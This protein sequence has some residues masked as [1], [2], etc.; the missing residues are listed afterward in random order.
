MSIRDAASSTDATA[1]S[2]PS[3]LNGPDEGDSVIERPL[4]PVSEKTLARA[5][6]FAE[7]LFSTEAGPPDRA[8]IDWLIED[9]R[10]FLGRAGGNARLVLWACL[11]ACHWLAPLFIR[12]LPTLADLSIE[13]RAVAL[14][15]VERSSFGPIV[16]GPK[17]ILCLLWFEHPDTQRE[18]RTEP[19]CLLPVIHE[20]GHS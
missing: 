20:G 18:T 7:A 10:D 19:S 13:E 12:R 17:A 1:Y 8:R 15:R 2:L 9:F 11:L 6:V 5:R 4:H 16:L 3:A 14:E